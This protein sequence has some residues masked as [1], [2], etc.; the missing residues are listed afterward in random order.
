MLGA[1]EGSYCGQA[2]GKVPWA[3]NCYEKSRGAASLGLFLALENH[4]CS[5]ILIIRECSTL[6]QG[7][8]DFRTSR[9]LLKGSRHLNLSPVSRLNET[10]IFCMQVD[11]RPIRDVLAPLQEAFPLIFFRAQN[12]TTVLT[13][14]FE[15]S[16]CL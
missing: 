5:I 13:G 2:Y 14:K 8:S 12:V 7:F 11:W 15:I 1:L 6:P 3:S 10:R 4:T 9:L 16:N